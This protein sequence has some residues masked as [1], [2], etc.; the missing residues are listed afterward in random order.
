[1]TLSNNVSLK[2]YNTFGIDA[3][4]NLFSNITSIDELNHILREHQNKPLFILGGGS[5]MLLTQDIDALVLHINL[6]GIKVISET[7]D[8]VIIRAMAGENWHDFVLWSL[9]HNYGGVENLSLIPGNIGTAPIQNIGA[10]GVE[11]KDVFFSCEAMNIKDQTTRIFSK[12]D[13][14]FGYRESVFKQHLKGEYII[15]S[16]N[17]QLTKN[18]HK[19]HIDYGAIKNELESLRIVNPTIKDISKAVIA[20]RQ[21][22]LPDPKNIGNSGSFFKNPII[23]ENH[24]KIL[25]ENFP[26]VPSYKISDNEVKVPAGWLI[27]KAGF[28]GKRFNDYGVHHKQALVLVNYGNASGNDIY[29]LAKLIQK[30]VKLLFDVTIEMEVNII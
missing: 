18:S 25:Q 10:Y 27:E 20:I 23:A 13:C 26:E 15:T 11:L 5:N 8:T 1:M 12:T 19:L 6:K 29:E 4:A 30:T 17:L 21:S 9:E 28:K 3:K 14:N 22:K 16:V 7:E 24:F 2:S